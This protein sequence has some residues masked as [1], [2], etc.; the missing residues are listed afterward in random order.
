MLQFLSL[1]EFYQNKRILTRVE[2]LCLVCPFYIKGLNSFIIYQSDIFIGI[3]CY[4][5]KLA[6]DRQENNRRYQC[7]EKTVGGSRKRF[8]EQGLG[9]A[10]E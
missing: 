8:E 9:M 7:C 1:H 5:G 2:I 6:M 4:T 10:L 3:R